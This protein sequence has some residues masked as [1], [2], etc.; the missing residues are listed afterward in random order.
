MK[1]TRAVVLLALLSAAARPAHAAYTYYSTL[2]LTAPMPVNS[3]TGTFT[4]DGLRNAT[5]TTILGS[6]PGTPAAYDYE[7]KSTLKLTDDWGGCFLHYLRASSDAFYPGNTGTFYAT[8]V[9]RTGPG[10]STVYIL[11]RVGGVVT[12]LAQAQGIW[13]DGMSMRSKMQGDYIG[14][15]LDDQF[16]AS[17]TGTEIASG[18]PGIGTDGQGSLNYMAT[19]MFGKIELVPPPALNNQSI[20]ATAS[21]NAVE[22]AWDAAQDDAEG[23][24]VCW[25]IVWRDG[26]VNGITLDP[27][28]YSPGV[29]P[30]HTYGYQILPVDFQ[31]ITYIEPVR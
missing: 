25:Y 21:P 7:V 9:C 18:Y 23:I 12:T 11:K 6:L 3:G 19:A 20:R 8:R 29:E 5:A 26:D 17:A 1:T 27:N 31:F 22:L 2:T 14:I 30:G 16:I 15:F 24:G 10:A 28:F 4:P 13:L